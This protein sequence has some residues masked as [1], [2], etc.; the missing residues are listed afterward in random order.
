MKPH[1]ETSLH[2]EEKKHLKSIDLTLVDN[3]LLVAV[4]KKDVERIAAAYPYLHSDRK[5]LQT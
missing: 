2:S 1:Y 4:K 5:L 3:S